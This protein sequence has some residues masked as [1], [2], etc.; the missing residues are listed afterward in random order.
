MHSANFTA[1]WRGLPLLP[2]LP[3]LLSVP[4][5]AGAAVLL[6]LLLPVPVAAGALEQPAPIRATMARAASDRSVLVMVSLLHVVIA[7]TPVRCRAGWSSLHPWIV[8]SVEVLG[9]ATVVD[10]CGTQF[11]VPGFV[12]VDL[13]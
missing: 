9:R 6:P 10:G 12:V 4:V 5:A 11:V 2:L 3:L 7:L 1:A 13:A 8:R